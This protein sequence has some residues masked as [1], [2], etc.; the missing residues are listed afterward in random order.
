L[1][2]GILFALIISFDNVSVSLFLVTARTTTLPIA[3]LNYVEYNFDP[4][5]AAI[6]TMLIGATA[7]AAVAIERTV[8]LR[9]VAG[10]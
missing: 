3:I 7:V 5:I 8:G 6:S 1:I 10:A 9:S 4:S 2:A